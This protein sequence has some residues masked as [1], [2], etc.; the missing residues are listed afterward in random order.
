MK[1]LVISISITLITVSLMMGNLR[2]YHAFIEVGTH[3]FWDQAG[4]CYTGHGE[5]IGLTVPEKG[6]LARAL[7]PMG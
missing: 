1:K 7:H 6:C 3:I 5:V 2:R 4:Q